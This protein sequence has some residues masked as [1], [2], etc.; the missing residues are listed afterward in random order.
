MDVVSARPVLIAIATVVALGL[1]ALVP[2][3]LR[4]DHG[5]TPAPAASTAADPHQAVHDTIAAGRLLFVGAS[6]TVG[7]GATSTADDYADLVADHL[8]R[9]FLVNAVPGTGFTNPGNEHQGT[10]AQRIATIPV[11]V[12]PRIVIIQGGRDDN[13]PPDVEQAAVTS[14]VE[15]ARHRFTSA[16]VVVLGPIPATVPISKQLADLNTAV[17]RGTT[18][19]GGGYV[20]PIAQDWI[21]RADEH[22]YLGKI[23]GHPDDLGYADFAKLLVEDLPEALAHAHAPVAPVPPVT[24]GSASAVRTSR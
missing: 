11:S 15:L 2:L 24:S 8:R 19:G 5:A 6:Y 1:V 21:T 4:D 17:E 18:A 23:P 10:F 7:W 13:A 3:T 22:G 12:D 20:D 14:T 16:Q 9:P